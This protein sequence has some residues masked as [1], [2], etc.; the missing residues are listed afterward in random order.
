MPQAMELNNIE[1][2]LRRERVVVA[3][4]LGILVLLA[5]LYVLQGAGTGMNVWAMT[6]WQLPALQ[7]HSDMAWRWDLHY[8]LLMLA[9]WWVMMVG[10]M[11]PSA[12]PMVLLYSRVLRH[13]QATAAVQP[14]QGSACFVLGYLLVWLAFSVAAVMAQWALEQLGLL[15]SMMMW[16]TSQACSALLLSA[17][18]L[19]QL[20]PFK[21]RCLHQC[22]APAEFIARYRRDG[23]LRMGLRHGLFCVGCCWLLMALLFVGGAMNLLWILGLSVL[24]LL[25]KLLP[26]AC[27]FRRGS[28]ALLL[29]AGAWLGLLAWLA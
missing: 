26:A 7:P 27:G 11:L 14:L 9:M 10:M 2:L 8:A 29:A 5:W 6:R 4:A 12:A 16:S 21:E 20:S 22:R 15:H 17:A 18:G 13:N 25:E 1:R 3:G 28:A 23:P 24:V 19:Y